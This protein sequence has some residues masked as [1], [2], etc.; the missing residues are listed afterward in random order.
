ML[1]RETLYREAYGERSARLDAHVGA[2]CVLDRRQFAVT[3]SARLDVAA[4]IVAHPFFPGGPPRIFVICGA[5]EPR[6]GGWRQLA[7][8]P[9]AIFL[10]A[11]RIDDAGDVA[12]GGEHE[13]D[14]A[15]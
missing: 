8:L 5:F 9:M 6:V 1:R 7:V 12:R 10:L 15:L 14:R 2:R 11:W 4:R 13:F 3:G